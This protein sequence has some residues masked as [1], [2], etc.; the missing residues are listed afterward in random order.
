MLTSKNTYSTSFLQKPAVLTNILR[1]SK[2]VYGTD[3]FQSLGRNWPRQGWLPTRRY[4]GH[5]SWSEYQ[6]YA[7]DQHQLKYTNMHCSVKHCIYW[8]TIFTVTLIYILYLHEYCFQS[9]ELFYYIKKVR[10]K[11]RECH[12]HKP[13]PLPR[14]RGN[15]QN[16]TSAN[17]TNARKALRLALSLN[18]VL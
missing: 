16:Q 14:E 10:E 12:N 2:N 8:N 17:R 3:C 6:M 4:G 1:K 15:R 13:Q 11:S 7:A 18:H 9:V 5:L